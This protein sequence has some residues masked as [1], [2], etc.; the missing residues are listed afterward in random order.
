MLKKYYLPPEIQNII[1]E[2]AKPLTRPDYKLGSYM[3]RSLNDSIGGGVFRL[4]IEYCYNDMEFIKLIKLSGI[5][6]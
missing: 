2:Y 4:Y 5:T 3:M 6:I 1:N